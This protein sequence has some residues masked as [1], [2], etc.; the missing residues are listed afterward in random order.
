MGR[1][2]PTYQQLARCMRPGPETCRRTATYDICCKAQTTQLVTGPGRFAS[3]RWKSCA[4]ERIIETAAKPWSGIRSS[5]SPFL[6][7]G[8]CE[9][10][11]MQVLHWTTSSSLLTTLAKPD[12]SRFGPSTCCRHCVASESALFSLEPACYFSRIY[13]VPLQNTRP[14]SRHISSAHPS[15]LSIAPISRPCPSHPLVAPVHRTHQ[16]PLSIAPIR[17]TQSSGS[18]VCFATAKVYVVFFELY[19][20][21]RLA[22]PVQ[23]SIV[24]EPER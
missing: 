4:A 2:G 15:P 14:A 13:E 10:C 18:S 5:R 9:P 19:E 12:S 20:K 3:L 17:R 16:S 24:G 23:T 22:R 1:L 8:L 11:R 7:S 6:F 21:L